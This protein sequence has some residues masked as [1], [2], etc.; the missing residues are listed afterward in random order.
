[1][2]LKILPHTRGVSH[3]L[4]PVLT[5]VRLVS[6]ARQEQLLWGTDCAAGHDYLLATK[7]HVGF[8]GCSRHVVPHPDRPVGIVKDDPFGVTPGR[9]RQIHARKRL[10]N[11]RRCRRDSLPVFDGVL[12]W[13]YTDAASIRIVVLK[14]WKPILNGRFDKMLSHNIQRR[15]LTNKHL[16]VLSPCRRVT[17]P[18]MVRLTALKVRQAF[19][20]RPPLTTKLAGPPIVILR[21]PPHPQHPINTR[22]TT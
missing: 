7:D 18:A 21:M 2:V 3:A 20:P 15:W 22:T 12:D 9:N 17:I 6:D 16:P 4:Y 14:Q 13:T 19:L 10:A 8:I 1:M 5:E 11:V